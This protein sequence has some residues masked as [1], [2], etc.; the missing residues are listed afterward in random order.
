MEKR[1]A[2][3][4]HVL[5][6]ATIEFGS[7][8]IRCVVRNISAT[9]AALDLSSPIE[10]PEHFTLALPADGQQMPCHVVWRN[11]RRIGVAF[12]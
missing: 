2:V 7:G 6:A 3:R 5:K 4:Q 11:D 12:D 8:E 9:G 10:I 1:A